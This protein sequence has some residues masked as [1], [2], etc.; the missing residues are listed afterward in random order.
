MIKKIKEPEA[1]KRAYETILKLLLK[2][3]IEGA[4]DFDSRYCYDTPLYN[5]RFAGADLLLYRGFSKRLFG[6]ENGPASSGKRIAIDS[7]GRGSGKEPV[8]S[9]PGFSIPK[10]HD[11]VRRDRID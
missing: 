3:Q 6:L 11:L 2:I 8:V 4:K 7:H 10:Y 9:L 1:I 5:G